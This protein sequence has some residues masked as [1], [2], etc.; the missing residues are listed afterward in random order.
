MIVSFFGHANTTSST[1][2]L[3]EQTIIEL[4]KHNDDISF[5]VGTHGA[6]DRM[7]QTALKSATEQ[8]SHIKAHIVLAYYDPT[9]I[10]DDWEQYK[11]PTIYPE[12]IEKAPKRFAIDFRN[13]YMINE[14]NTIICYISHDWGGAAKYVKIA[15]KKHKK[16]INLAKQQ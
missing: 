10:K 12:G 1:Y 4:S 2:P 6:F 16:I 9:V 3:L 13:K 7:A 11:L 8:Y 5:L 14:C 15:E